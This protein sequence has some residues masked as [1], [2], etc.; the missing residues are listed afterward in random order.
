LTERLLRAAGRVIAVEIDAG[1]TARLRRRFAAEARLTLV[2]DDVL[3]V[4][5]PELLR[6]AGLEE[7]QAY[8][9]AGNLPY[10]AGAAI[11]RHFLEAAHPPR[12]L[13][14]MLQREVAAAITAGPGSLGLLG[15]AT[16]VYSQPKRL[17]D[18][19]P[20]AFS[21]P[22]KVTSTVLTL[23]LRA[24]ALVPAEERRQ[25]FAV[26]RGGFATPRKQ[27]HNSLVAGLRADGAAVERALTSAGVDARLRPQ[28]LTIAQWLR[29]SR[30]LGVHDG[31]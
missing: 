17:F 3:A 13:L 12:R 25:F 2:Q 14:V 31:A 24:E 15:V 7:D 22:P 10:N 29:L 20:R 26:V 11:L 27:L 8:V 18:V 1:L 19:A 4:A 30:G 23:D 21:P 6:A 28:D 5:P 9:V 16:Q